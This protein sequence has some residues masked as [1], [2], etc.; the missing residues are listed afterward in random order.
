MRA[1]QRVELLPVVLGPLKRLL[2]ASPRRRQGLDELAAL[3]GEGVVGG[4]HESAANY[5]QAV[6]IFC[7]FKLRA[8]LQLRESGDRAA[9]P[10]G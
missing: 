7:K 4:G 2:L 10:C 3:A 6:T 8:D 1:L 9:A 5:I